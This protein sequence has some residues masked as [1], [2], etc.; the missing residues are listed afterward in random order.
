MEQTDIVFIAPPAYSNAIEQKPNKQSGHLPNLGICSLAAVVEREGYKVFILDAVALQYSL[1]QVVDEVK[2]KNPK[3]V[4][5]SAMTH[6]ISYAAMVAKFIKEKC[7]SVKIILGGVHITSATEETLKKYPEYFDVAIIG[8]GE[9]TLI[10][11]MR[12]FENREVL[13]K[14]AGIAFLVNGE[15]VKTKP[16]ELVK[17][18]DALPFPAW[19][20]LP[21]LR[22]HYTPTLISAGG[23]SSNHLVT[24]RG[25]PGKCIFCDTSVTGHMVRGYSADY[26]LEMIDIL[27]K[28][29]KID[30]I[31]FNDDTF[32]TLRKRLFDICE[33]LISK[34]YKL[35]WSCDARASDVTEEGLKLMKAAGCW[36]IAYGVETGSPRIMEF[37][38]KRV[39]FDQ[40]RN[41]C[42]WAK[43]AGIS[44]KGFFIIGHPTETRE[45][46][47]ETLDFM[48]S[49]DLDVI[50]VTFFTVY[51]GSPIYSSIHEYGTFNP[52]WNCV[53]TY[54]VGNF[55]PNG[56]TAE[57]LAEFRKH[58]L[59][60]FYFRPRQI[61][62]YVANVRSV[63]DLYRLVIGGSKVL[64]RNV[65]SF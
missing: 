1:L 6:S 8:E 44:T 63:Y 29:Y 4:G 24:S 27:H 3:Y 55:L 21:D 25:C 15:V 47:Q 19:H 38:K 32:V 43:K 65:L 42:K 50:G 61:L 45:S 40:I 41:A 5:L 59:M 23:I 2:T 58:I 7:P 36:Q 16:R 10:E 22:T 35:K 56:F 17:N 13:S 54:E 12:T 11:L 9:V 18:M 53:N 62:K 26:V 46:I 57:E 31:Q 64:K 33:K 39:T 37:L 49:L 51:P 60:R 14:V 52:D 48:L 34:N 28:K 30:D 20:L